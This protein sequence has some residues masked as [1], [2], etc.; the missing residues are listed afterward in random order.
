M[1][2]T[3]HSGHRHS[4]NR[5]HHVRTQRG[6]NQQNR[7][8][9]PTRRIPEPVWYFTGVLLLLV[10]VKLLQSPLLPPAI[11]GLGLVILSVSRLWHFKPG[12]V[13]AGI[14]LFSM[15]FLCV[16]LWIQ[17][18][19]GVVLS[20]TAPSDTHLFL[21]GTTLMT[22]LAFLVWT[23]YRAFN[24]LYHHMGRK[25]FIKKP[26]LIIVKL[27]FYFHLF[28]LVFWALAYL[29]AWWA[30]TGGW[31]PRDAAL[32]AGAIALVAAGFPAIF[33]LSRTAPH[34]S[35]H[36]HHRHSAREESGTEKN[37]EIA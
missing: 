8:R 14:S 27:L 36:R 21:A 15:S 6:N 26:Y 32:A 37:E 10:A 34:G 25:W 13:V 29:T 24:R 35:A 30:Q 22:I 19:L 4:H 12:I 2:P 31:S 5:S 9:T 33:Y 23:Y 11:G 7:N 20:G 16:W 18:Y 3:A 1:S 17:Q 28:L